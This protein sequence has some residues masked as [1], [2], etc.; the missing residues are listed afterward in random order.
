MGHQ[1]RKAIFHQVSSPASSAGGCLLLKTSEHRDGPT[2]RLHFPDTL[3]RFAA[4]QTI[5]PVNLFREILQNRLRR[6]GF[7]CRPSFR[8]P[9]ITNFPCKIPCWQGIRP[10]T[11]SNQTASPARP[12]SQLQ[13]SPPRPLDQSARGF[14]DA[15]ET[16]RP[17][18][19]MVSRQRPTDQAPSIWRKHS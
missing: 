14:G 8:A 17:Y 12:T 9:A 3:G 2:S 10:E 7:R 11:G 13:F 16:A 6:S 1:A 18:L 5:F 15:L 19:A 4:R